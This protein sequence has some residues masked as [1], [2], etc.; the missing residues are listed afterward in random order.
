MI[1]NDSYDWLLEVLRLGQQF[2]EMRQPRA[3]FVASIHTHPATWYSCIA[4][5]DKRHVP[6]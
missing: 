5:W 2:E 3:S 1:Q 4:M 6:R